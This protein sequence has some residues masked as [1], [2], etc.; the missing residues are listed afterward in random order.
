[1]RTVI[2]AALVGLAFAAPAEAQLLHNSKLYVGTLSCNV[3][4]SVGFVF[5]S[6]KELSCVLVRPDGSAEDYHGRVNRFGID[7]GFTKAMHVLW[8]VYSLSESAPAGALAGDYMGRQE[9]ITLGGTAR[10][11]ILVGGANEAIL[12]D[13]VAIRGGH[14]GYNFADGLAEISLSQSGD[15]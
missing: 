10:S 5:G 8:H 9:S 2:C 3:S 15:I 4:G 6:T 1:M 13:S 7:L 11:N 14:N 12:L